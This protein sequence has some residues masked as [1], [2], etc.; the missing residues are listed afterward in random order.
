MS[1]SDE[2]QGKVRVR[3]PGKGRVS[4]WLTGCM[5]CTGAAL[6]VRALFLPTE[7][8][9]KHVQTGKPAILV[10]GMCGCQPGLAGTAFLQRKKA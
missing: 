8:T 3:A 2:F 7:S 1:P 5:L 10:S 9:A 6:L 4:V